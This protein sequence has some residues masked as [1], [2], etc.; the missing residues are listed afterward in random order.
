MA[1]GT[2][3]RSLLSFLVILSINVGAQIFSDKDVEICKSKF[4]L[5]VSESLSTQPI[6]KVIVEIGKSFIGTDYEAHAIEKEGEEQLVINLTGLDCTTFLE[7][8]LV[9]ARCIKKGK[10]S[11]EDY[12]KEL[13]FIRYR[14]GIIN[15]YP[16]RLH[17]FTDWIYNNVKK[18]VVKDV[19]KDIGGE[20][21]RLDLFFMSSHLEYYRQ[22]KE[23]P[24]FVP[25]IKKQEEEINKREYYFIPQNKIADIDD[26]IE[27]GDLLAFTSSIPGLDVNHVGI[28]IRMDDNRIHVLHAPE[29]GTKVQISELNLSDYVN[30]LEKDTGIIV[31]KPL[32]P[33]C[34]EN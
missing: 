25:I 6:G 10:T 18:G 16:S 3:Y 24:E 34:T 1:N 7:N 4:E 32:E 27:D 28:A 17:Y 22:L 2:V 13:T 15:K 11:F 12:E 29:P 26:E 9:F 5:A 19:T 33:A 14:N 23:N 8:V 30:K 21:L 20:R 31:L